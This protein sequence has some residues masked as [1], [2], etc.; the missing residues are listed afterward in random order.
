MGDHGR[1][2]ENADKIVG[3]QLGGLLWEGDVLELDRAGVSW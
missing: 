1:D 2:C 3:G